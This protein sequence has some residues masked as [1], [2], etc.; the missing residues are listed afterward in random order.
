[1][2]RCDLVGDAFAALIHED[3]LP[4]RWI[5]AREGSETWAELLGPTHCGTTTVAAVISFV[6][7]RIMAERRRMVVDTL[8]RAPRQMSFSITSELPS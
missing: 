5:S 4:R 8:P 2:L 6:T 3:D 1:V 7:R